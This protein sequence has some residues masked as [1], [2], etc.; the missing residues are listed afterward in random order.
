MAPKAHL[1]GKNLLFF[2]CCLLLSLY[3]CKN[4]E[5]DNA[6]VGYVPVNLSDIPLDTLN[7]NEVKMVNG[8]FYAQG[9]PFSGYIKEMYPNNQL[10]RIAS[11]V[12]GKLYG[13]SKSFFE[14]GSLRDIRSY[15]DNLAYG[16]H[17]GYWQN[18]KLQFDFFYINE[19]SEGI[20]RQWYQNGQQYFKFNLI[21]DLE[22]G[23]QKAWRENGKLFINY[24][25]KD[26]KRYGLQKS[27]LCYTLK[28]EKLK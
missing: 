12:D 2:L 6:K 5:R 23:T 11:Y 22:T 3:A 26:G 20:Q 14:N 4:K 25:V 19:K 16:R 8:I 18:G 15:R 1:R 21:N 13:I 24:E 10:Q 28:N 7:D 9:K 17:I 27:S